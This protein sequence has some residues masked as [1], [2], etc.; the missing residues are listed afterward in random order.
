MNRKTNIFYDANSS[1]SS[2]LTFNNYTE[3]LTG[4]ILSIDYKLW[5]SR[6]LCIYIENL[7]SET[8]QDFVNKLQNYYENKLATLRDNLDDDSVIKPLNYLLTFLYWWSYNKTYENDQKSPFEIEEALYSGNADVL[9]CVELN[10]ISDIVE[11]QYNGTYSDIICTINPSKWHKPQ[12][13]YIDLIDDKNEEIDVNAYMTTP[14]SV[15]ELSS[16]SRLHGWENENNQ[17]ILEKVSSP[18]EDIIKTSENTEEHI[19]YVKSLIK[20]LEIIEVNDA[21]NL[22][23]NL[24]IPLFNVINTVNSNDIENDDENLTSIDLNNKVNIPLGIYFTGDDINLSIN[25]NFATNW[26]LLISTQ[27][28]AFPFSFDIQQNFDDSQSTKQAYITFAQILAKQTDVTDALTKYDNLVKSLQ[29]RI[30]MLESKLNNISSVQN[31]D[32]IVQNVTNLSN[33]IENYI[34]TINNK[35]EQLDNKIEDSKLKWQI[36]TKNNTQ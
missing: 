18:I 16:V 34:S 20:E 11:Q 15:F 3:A 1:D 30:I 9:S 7:T 17:S 22:K 8:K 25:G 4:D 6:F 28:S 27:F 24:V 13:K 26:S 12:I 33:K 14:N 19:Y 29:E 36:S 35:L 21:T 23:F 5:P 2:F 31:I 10:Y 32:S